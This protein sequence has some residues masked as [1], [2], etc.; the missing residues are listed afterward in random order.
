[1][2]GSAFPYKGGACAYH[3]PC[4]ASVM[5]S[6]EAMSCEVWSGESPPPDLCCGACG[7]ALAPPLPVF[8]DETEPPSGTWRHAAATRIGRHVVTA[9]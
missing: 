7:R 5:L 4:A 9:L 2:D 6:R 3:Q 8:S 1:M